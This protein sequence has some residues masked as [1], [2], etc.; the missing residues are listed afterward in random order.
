MENICRNCQYYVKEQSEWG[1]CERTGFPNRQ[2]RKAGDS[3]ED[4]SPNSED[5]GF[6]E[7]AISTIFVVEPAEIRPVWVAAVYGA[8]AFLL[9]LIF[10]DV[11]FGVPL[12]P[13]LTGCA[14]M[15]LLIIG[16]IV[17]TIRHHD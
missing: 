13:E 8:L 1:Y 4:Y 15:V 11:F 10:I 2:R 16:V 14:V 12:V 3:C 17:W 5:V 9:A 6:I 7:E